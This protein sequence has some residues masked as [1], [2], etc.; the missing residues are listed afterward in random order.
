GRPASGNAARAPAAASCGATGSGRVRS[1]G[2]MPTACTWK[3]WRPEPPA[4]YAAP[5]MRRLH[6]AQRLQ[7]VLVETG[8][9]PRLDIE[10]AV[11]VAAGIFLQQLAET[12]AR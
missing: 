5:G 1:D 3:R 10:R 7:F 6:V 8:Q 12:G 11:Q 2:W 9:Q 4:R